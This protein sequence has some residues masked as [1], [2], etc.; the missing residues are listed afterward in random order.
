MPILQEAMNEYPG[1]YRQAR[2]IQN[3]SM[4]GL[5]NLIGLNQAFANNTNSNL[6]DLITGRSPKQCT[7][8]PTRSRNS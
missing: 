7:T 4:N 5:S 8:K 3:N 6:T 1:L 2:E